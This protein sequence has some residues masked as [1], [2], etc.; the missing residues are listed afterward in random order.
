M[1]VSALVSSCQ[2]AELSVGKP[3][4]YIP[5]RA[6][7]CAEISFRPTP[8]IGN[9]TVMSTLTAHSRRENGTTR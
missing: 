4:I 5:K 3:G 8:S 6:E 9:S 2:R 1:L 7:V